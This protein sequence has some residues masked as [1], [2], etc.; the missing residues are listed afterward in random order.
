MSS[1]LDQILDNFVEAVGRLGGSLGI[2]RVASQLYALLYLKGRPLSLNEM[3]DYLKVSKGNVSVNI[4]ELERWGAVKKIWKKGSRRDFYQAEEDV[5]RIM[6]T[7]LREG[8]NKRLSPVGEL[9][10]EVENSLNGNQKETGKQEKV[11][12]E[13]IKQAKEIYET[14]EQ[15][16]QL[17]SQENI[18]LLLSR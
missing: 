14:I 16:L 12:R 2:S 1:K 10:K 17:L 8:M 6:V 9:L 11:Y 15:G 7:R 4:R 13:K 18:E 3:V 5:L